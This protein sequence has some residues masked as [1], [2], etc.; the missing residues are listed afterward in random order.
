MS[1]VKKKQ[2]MSQSTFV[3]YI[4]LVTSPVDTGGY[5]LCHLVE[6]YLYMDIW[7]FILH[8]LKVTFIL[9]LYKIGSFLFS[10]ISDQ[11][12]YILCKLQYERVKGMI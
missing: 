3:A 12:D 2:N 6:L 1:L 7:K 4:F 11:I 9:L 5:S 10:L 8:Y